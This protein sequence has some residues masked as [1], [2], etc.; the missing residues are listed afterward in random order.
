MVSAGLRHPELGLSLTW[1][2][3]IVEDQDRVPQGMA[4]TPGFTVHDL[5]LSW[6]PQHRSLK[7]LRVDFAV[8]NLGDRDFREHLSLL[9]SPGRNFKTSLAWRF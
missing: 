1:R 8:D 7:G 4:D 3:R 6:Q 2:T 5:R 9:K